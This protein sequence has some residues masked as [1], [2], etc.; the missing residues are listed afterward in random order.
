MVLQTLKRRK[1]KFAKHY[2]QVAPEI[3]CGT[4][5]QTHASNVYS[6]GRVLQK[7]SMELQIS[8]LSCLAYV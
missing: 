1:E 5:K 3:C 6:F 8:A 7:I 2:P 4:G